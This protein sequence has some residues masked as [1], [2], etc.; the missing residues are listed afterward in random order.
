MKSS[1][2]KSLTDS[3]C[4]SSGDLKLSATQQLLFSVYKLDFSVSSEY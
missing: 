2:S 4:F 3:Q 1:S